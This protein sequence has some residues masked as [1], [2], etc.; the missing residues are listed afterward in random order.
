MTWRETSQGDKFWRALCGK[1]PSDLGIDLPDPVSFPEVKSGMKVLL[2]TIPELLAT[3]G[4]TQ[5]G[6]WI[7]LPESS[8]VWSHDGMDD[9]AG[10]IVTI[11]ECGWTIV[12][13]MVKSIVPDTPYLSKAD[14]PRV[15]DLIGKKVYY[16]DSLDRIMGS[17]KDLE[18]AYLIAA[19]VGEDTRYPF[20]VAGHPAASQ[21]ST[22]IYS[23]V[24]PYVEP[25]TVEV[26]MEEVCSKFGKNV[27]IKKD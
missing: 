8:T 9:L 25:E 24:R 3:P 26:T 22:C 23:Y 10:T 20:R 21:D 18:V 1:I 17:T 12:G 15:K 14:D 11:G 27:K 5:S 4:A 6:G 19:R 2:K 7:S 13:W 16:S